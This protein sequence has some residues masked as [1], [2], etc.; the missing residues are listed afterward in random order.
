MDYEC[1]QCGEIPQADCSVCGGTGRV[2]EDVLNQH[3]GLVVLRGLMA[4]TGYEPEEDWEDIDEDDLSEWDESRYDRI[5]GR[6]VSEDVK[7]VA[8]TPGSRGLRAPDRD[9]STGYHLSPF[10]GSPPEVLPTAYDTPEEAEAAGKA[11]VR[12]YET[13]AFPGGMGAVVAVG[14]YG[15][16]F[17]PVVARYYSFS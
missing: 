5:I 7:R 9:P 3:P 13:S 1:P 6:L 15:G 8:L 12:E 14:T 4:L 17:H 10:A 2:S 16:K 11:W